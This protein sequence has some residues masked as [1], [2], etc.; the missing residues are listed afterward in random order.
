MLF[1]GLWWFVLSHTLPGILP[2]VWQ[3]F[4]G[5]GWDRQSPELETEAPS[6]QTT[7][8]SVWKGNQAATAQ[9]Q[10]LQRD[11]LLQPGGQHLRNILE[12]VFMKEND[13]CAGRWY[14]LGEHFYVQ[15]RV[16]C[17]HIAQTKIISLMCVCTVMWS[18]FRWEQIYTPKSKRASRSPLS[19]TFHDNKRP[20][21]GGLPA[22]LSSFIPSQKALE[23]ERELVSEEVLECIC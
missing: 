7:S 9:N 20:H 5:R 19:A 10:F 1:P 12:S 2:V 11:N 22:P 4:D 8:L 6:C 17:L 14:G 15:F 16:H 23:I 13:L 18:S 21:D 3:C